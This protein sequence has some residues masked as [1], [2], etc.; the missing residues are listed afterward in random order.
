MEDEAI[1]EGFQNLK[2]GSE[3]DNLYRAAVCREQ[4]DWLV[5]MNATRL[6]SCLYGQTLPMGRVMSPTLAMVVQR[7][8]KIQ[9]FVSKEHYTVKLDLGLI[10]ASGEKQEEM[11]TAQAIQTACQQEGQAEIVEYQRKEKQEKPPLLHDLTSLQR[12]A[13]RLLGY[14]AQ[15]T[16]DYA[17]SLY[18]KKLIT[19]PRTDSK[20]LPEDMAQGLNEI[21][22]T[23]AQIAQEMFPMDVSGK[24]I[25]NSS[26]V[27]DHHAIIPTQTA[28][29]QELEQ[30]PTGER[31]LLELLSRRCLAAVDRSYLRLRWP[32]R[33]DQ[34]GLGS[35]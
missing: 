35:G 28:R 17:Q 23:S 15:Q 22:M 4:A 24:R 19:Y 30:L 29:E 10:E 8:D 20:F 11:K 12:E 1:R 7:E 13:N 2:P 14:T 16:L 18:E 25:C 26:K 33:C 27:T 9:N 32:L 3:Y 21:A 34:G 6:F 5:G 31:K